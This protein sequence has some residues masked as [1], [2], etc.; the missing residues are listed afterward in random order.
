MTDA[1]QSIVFAI[2]A[3]TTPW[4]RQERKAQERQ[5]RQGRLI[6]VFDKW[7]G[8]DRQSTGQRCTSGHGDPDMPSLREGWTLGS[9]LPEQI[10]I[11]V[12]EE[13]AGGR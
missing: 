13:S 5:E 7:K 8:S 9:Q 2:I 4:R 12:Q 1:V 3:F 6:I 11:S 10:L